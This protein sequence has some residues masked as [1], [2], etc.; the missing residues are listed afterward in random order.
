MSRREEECRRG[1]G[2]ASLNTDRKYIMYRKWKT[3]GT[4]ACRNRIQLGMSEWK[5]RRNGQYGNKGRT[6][7]IVGS[8]TDSE[9]GAGKS[10]ARDGR[11]PYE[12]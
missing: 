11:P 1:T 4:P 8:E 3:A 10:H 6:A 9:S 5:A 12:R 2:V 7:R